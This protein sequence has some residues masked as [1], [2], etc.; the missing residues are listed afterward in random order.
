MQTQF[1]FSMLLCL[2]VLRGLVLRNNAVSREVCFSLAAGE[3]LED[4]HLTASLLV[5]MATVG[6]NDRNE[7]RCSGP[8]TAELGQNLA[9]TLVADRD[10]ARDETLCGSKAYTL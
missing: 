5:E 7:G 4:H 8:Q 2:D 6:P 1:C 3:I 9:R 10:E